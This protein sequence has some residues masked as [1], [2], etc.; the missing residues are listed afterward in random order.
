MRFVLSF[1]SLFFLC[2]AFISKRKELPNT[3]HEN[4]S[5]IKM[6]T[7]V[8]GFSE[9]LF[10]RLYQICS[11]CYSP[12]IGKFLPLGSDAWKGDT[13]IDCSSAKIKIKIKR[14]RVWYCC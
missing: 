6:A 11:S 7:L 9:A 12:E 4:K 2:L 1:S 5:E 13:K 3:I 14:K 10:K 8:N